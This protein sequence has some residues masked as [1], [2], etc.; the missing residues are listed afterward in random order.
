MKSLSLFALLMALIPGPALA[1]TGSGLVEPRLVLPASGLKQTRV[2]LTFDA[3]DGRTD[4]RILD[5][6]INNAIPATIFV[7]GRWLKNNRIVFAKLLARPDLFEI[8]NH[9]LSHV[10]L[11]DYPGRV[12]GLRDAGSPAGV[13]REVE[14]GEQ[15][16]R[17]AGGTDARWFRGATAEYSPSAMRMIRKLGLKIAGFSVNADAGATIG[18]TAAEKRLSSV[19]DGD[20]VIAHINQPRRAAG[21]GVAKGILDLKARGVRFVKLSD[22]AAGL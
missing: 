7:T 4:M 22:R 17:A 21:A 10:P 6:L 16:I 15:A 3:C 11:V 9:G 19:H 5:T 13:T 1:R 18:A 8:G 12:Y 2:A 20:V 14:G